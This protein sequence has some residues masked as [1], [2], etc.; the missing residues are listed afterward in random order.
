VGENKSCVPDNV[1]RMHTDQE[2]IFYDKTI[3]RPFEAA[4][5]NSVRQSMFFGKRLFGHLFRD[6]MTRR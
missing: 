5:M 6:G 3:D 2:F 4:I 1:H